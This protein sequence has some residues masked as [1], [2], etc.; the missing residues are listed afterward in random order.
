MQVK[1]GNKH[2]Q[3]TI[4]GYSDQGAWL[5]TTVYA[6]D[7][8]VSNGGT[9]YVCLV[10]HT[11]AA[12]D[13]PGVGADWAD[14]WEILDSTT[15]P[16]EMQYYSKGIL[17]MPDTWDA[18]DIGFQVSEDADGPYLPLYQTDG[19][20]EGFTPAVDR[21]YAFPS[22]VAGAKYVK[23]WSNSAGTDVEQSAD[24]V[25]QLDFKA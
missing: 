4:Q 13:E 8:M 2:Q 15:D 16:F 1:L 12:G 17:H 20:L 25:F 14:F 23:L 6:V 7:E 9:D 24:R 22:S 18:A 11:A 19:T 3:V 10:G 21:S 5:I